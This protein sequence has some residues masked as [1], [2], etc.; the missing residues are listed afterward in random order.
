MPSAEK[1]T[2][3]PHQ[4]EAVDA[5]VRGLDIPPGKKI[6]QAGLR[7]TVVAAC[8]TGKTFIAA[9]S[10][11]R[12]ARNGR[13]LVLLPTLDLLTQTVREWRA[14]GHHGPAVAVCSLEDDPHLWDLKVRSTTSAPQLALW[15]G[16]GPVTV[17]ATYASLPV[18]AE[19]HEGV[20]GLP[21][22]VF[23]LVVVDEA[24]RT[25]GSAGKAWA[26]VHDQDVIPAMRRLYM[27]ATP[28]IWKERPP[29]LSWAERQERAGM[30]RDRLPQEMACSMD[31]PKVFGPVVYELSLASAV[32]RGLLARYQIV[33]VELTDP[34]VTP[35]RL[36]G[37]ERRDE[38]VRGERMGALQAALLETM[39]EHG[40]QTTI[41]FHHRTVEAAAFAGGLGRVAKRL[42][43]ADSER[44]PERVWADWLCG[45]H[46]ADHRRQVLAD[47]GRRAGR[48]VLSNC[49]VLGEGVDIR[50]VDSVALLDPKGSAV[51][52]VQAIGRA[53][54]QK[55]GEGK[56]ATLIVPVFLA[57][58]EKPEDMLTSNSYR[59]LVKVLE[60]LRA[61][62]ERAIEL[63]AIPQEQRKAVV[64]PS[65]PI[66][67]PPEEGQEDTR[68]LLRFAAPR[69]PVMIAKWVRFNVISTERQDW[70]R[71][72]DAA[73]RYFEREGDL[74]VPYEHTEGAYPLGRWLSDQRR[75]Y[76][77]GTMNGERADELEELGMVWDTAD[78]AFE[79]NLA[80]ARAYF[81]EA[82]TLAA[83]RH[84]TALDRPVGQWLTNLRR[85]GGLGK[86]TDRARRR[87]E[88]LAA[89]DPDWNPRLL[90]WTVDW[91]R[92][93]VG[94]HALLDAGSALEDVQSGVTYRGDDI[95]RWTARQARDWAQLNAEQR[96]RLE[97]LGVRP[98]AAVRAQKAP[99]RGAAKAG[100]GKGS[101]AFQ[102]GVEALRQYIAREGKTTV[103]RQHVEEL[104][105]GTSV[106]LGVFLS[107]H[108]SRRDRLSED[109][110]AALA[111]LGLEWA[112]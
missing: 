75:S 5:V 57:P 86:D 38:D 45:D 18:L 21:M 52:I 89:I 16:R 60:G 59:P 94:L 100:A 39:A 10:A 43:A 87:A 103:G 25:S 30:L 54:R 26:A 67:P 27:T 47:F 62:D 66:G 33:V 70:Q 112:A 111:G 37:P 81:T 24:H 51:D 106:R 61:H 69:D 42:H 22:D 105:D 74:E 50:A 99:V 48:A 7:A 107:N 15:H 71:G 32:S 23:D 101:D 13:V 93:Y 77:A 65:P 29:R 90:G 72:Y 84:A 56:M 36:S 76:R 1:F 31:D 55:P 44:Y 34:V 53:L 82:G 41:T 73:R 98:R 104:P 9:H 11:L 91:Q 28:R 2:L 95:G 3:R 49:R 35:A 17:Y 102:R 83:P 46:E 63:L 88:Q 68:P 20:Y 97:E 19:A 79:E 80:A 14:A 40:L 96:R 110:L 85:P 8:G 108:K 64:D 58:G 4:I 92:C 78:A 109:Q 6:P 12:L